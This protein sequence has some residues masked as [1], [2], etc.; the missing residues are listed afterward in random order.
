MKRLLTSA[1]LALMTVQ[2]GMPCIMLAPGTALPGQAYIEAA[3]PFLHLIVAIKRI[4][5]TTGFVDYATGIKIGPNQI[6]TAAHVV[7]ALGGSFNSPANLSV[8]TGHNFLSPT[9]NV[10]VAFYRVHPSYIQGS[11]LGTGSQIDLAVIHTTIAMDGPY[12]VIGT[13]PL[14]NGNILTMIGAGRP[15]FLGGILDPYD[16]NFRA[17]RG[18]LVNPTSQ[19]DNLYYNGLNASGSSSFSLPGGGSLG[20]SGGAGFTA[21]NEVVFLITSGAYGGSSVRTIGVDLTN[22]EIHNFIASEP[23]K[24][25][26]TV[27]PTTA[28]LSFADLIRNRQYRVMRS[29]ALTAWT[30]SHRFTAAS[31]TATWSESLATSGKMF[32]RLEWDE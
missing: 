22:P 3:N 20:C 21:N 15:G 26:L 2:S 1:M 12:A 18:S 13:S 29:S 19:F 24:L 30:E 28:Q 17:C 14:A 16:G 11:G 10:S 27:S 9:Q 32:Y 8:L 7:D 4:S 5:P 6:L 23:P 25:T 31:D